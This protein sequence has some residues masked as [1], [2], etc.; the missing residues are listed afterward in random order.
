MNAEKFIM[1]LDTLFSKGEIDKV[2]PFIKEQLA[3]SYQ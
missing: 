3:L 2:A 1:Q